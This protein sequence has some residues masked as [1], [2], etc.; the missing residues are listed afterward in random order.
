MYKRIIRPLLFR[1][2]PE[3]IHNILIGVF[4]VLKYVPFAKWTI[5]QLFSYRDRKLEREVFGLRFPNPVGLAAGFDKNAEVYDV[6]GAMGFGFVEIGTV[7]P[8]GQP[9]NPKPRSFRL[10][11]DK[12]LIN[13]MGFNNHGVENAVRNLRH[14]KPGLI[15][16][17]NIGKNTVTTNENAPADYLRIFRSMYDY[18]D[19][20]TVN[21]SCPNVANLRHL[22]NKDNIIEILKPLKDFRKG[23]SDYRPILLKISPDLEPAQVD[24]M[25]EVVKQCKIDGI[26]ATNTTT[27]REGLRTSPK[28]VREI[29]NGGLSGAPLTV[30]SLEMIRYIRERTGGS[31]PIIGVGGIM[32]PNDAKAMLKAGATLVQVYSGFIYEGPTLAARICRAAAA[33]NL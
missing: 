15:V 26:V 33:E 29:G 10:P 31:L 13:R 3:T 14:R 17:G 8:K 20:F 5:R 2:Q 24:M 9:G 28:R 16:G 23:Q 19:Y 21:V 6:V 4:R 22:Q 11:E 7:T 32:T 25:I 12:A 30:R 27:S 18:V 1:L